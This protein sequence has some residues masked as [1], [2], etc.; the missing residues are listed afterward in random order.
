MSTLSLSVIQAA[1]TEMIRHYLTSQ[2]RDSMNP[3]L[4]YMLF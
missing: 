1:V 4:M 3:L 2:N